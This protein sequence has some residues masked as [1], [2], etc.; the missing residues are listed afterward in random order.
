MP[1]NELQMEDLAVQNAEAGGKD[2]SKFLYEEVYGQQGKP[3]LQK[4]AGDTAEGGKGAHKEM[5]P[6]D[7]EEAIKE[8]NL[9]KVGKLDEVGDPGF[10]NPEKNGINEG[11]IGKHLDYLWRSREVT[12]ED[13]QEAIEKMH[14]QL[15]KDSL[16]DLLPAGDRKAIHRLAESVL[17]GDTKAL[18]EIAATFK[19]DPARL[20]AFCKHVESELKELGAK[21]N[22]DV[23]GDGSLLVYESRGNHAI[24]VGADGVTRI[25]AIAT[26]WDGSVDILTDREPLRP[27]A[28]ELSKEIANSAVRGIRDG[29]IIMYKDD[30]WKFP[31]PLG[32]YKP[33]Y[34][35][36][37]KIEF[38][39]YKP[40][41]YLPDAI[42][43]EFGDSMKQLMLNKGEKGELDFQPK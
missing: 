38:P 11:G 4:G 24:Q 8:G 34:R 33:S 12:K 40:G 28:V 30:I 10:W 6:L 14:K 2:A 9:K 18:S 41:K 35:Y 27:T 29:D 37:P 7:I 21:V 19:G 5:K 1:N 42:Y 36:P 16:L 32:P 31:G 25:R 26:N 22:L 43:N 15:G 39:P 17:M 23:A 20:R 13:R 3:A